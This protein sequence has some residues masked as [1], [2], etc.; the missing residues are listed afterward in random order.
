MNRQPAAV[1]LRTH[2]VVRFGW[3]H[4]MLAPPRYTPTKWYG[5]E[6]HADIVA[7]LGVAHGSKPRP[8]PTVETWAVAALGE[9]VG[10]LPAGLAGRRRSPSASATVRE[11]ALHVAVTRN[12]RSRTC[13]EWPSA[14][15]RAVP[16][17]R[18]ALTG[19][20]T[21][22]ASVRPIWCARQR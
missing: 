17:A 21:R 5:E 20:W 2:E 14:P 9:A 8:V 15:G 12:P 6:C 7:E 11:D 4:A 16:V 3:L 13:A 18:A 22:I 1:S 10:R 19:L